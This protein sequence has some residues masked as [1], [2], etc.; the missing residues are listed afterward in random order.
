MSTADFPFVV[1]IPA[2][3]AGYPAGSVV[4]RGKTWGEALSVASQNDCFAATNPTTG[5]C[6]QIPMQGSERTGGG[7]R[8]KERAD[9]VVD[10]LFAVDNDAAE[11]GK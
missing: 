1:R 8:G 4:F 10:N 3:I 5:Q 2:G 7:L 11:Q 9:W 6:C